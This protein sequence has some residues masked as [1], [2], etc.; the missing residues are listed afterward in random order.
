ME[1][2]PPASET[3]VLLLAF[4]S[5]VTPA[6]GKPVV[7]DLTT[8]FTVLVCATTRED[9]KTKKTKAKHVIIL[10]IFI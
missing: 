6:S 5:T 1:K 7:F 8:P 4:P 9:N 10:V 2:L 3:L